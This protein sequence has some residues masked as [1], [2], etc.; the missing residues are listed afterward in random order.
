[1]LQLR[2]GPGKLRPRGGFGKLWPHRD[3][4]GCWPRRGPKR[5]GLTEAQNRRLPQADANKVK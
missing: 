2:G 1:M 5:T 3:P 4:R